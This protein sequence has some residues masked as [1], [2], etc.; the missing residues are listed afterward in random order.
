[1]LCC[2]FV[3]VKRTQDIYEVETVGLVTGDHFRLCTV[4]AT[5]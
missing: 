2:P 5:F 3:L 4:W 1:M